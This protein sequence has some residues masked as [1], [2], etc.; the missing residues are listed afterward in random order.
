LKQNIAIVLQCL[1]KKLNRI[2][3]VHDPIAIG[4]DAT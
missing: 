4:C 1:I 2:V 3:A